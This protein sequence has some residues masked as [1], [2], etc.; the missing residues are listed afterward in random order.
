MK[1]VLFVSVIAVLRLSCDQQS[2]ERIQK[3]NSTV[4]RHV[5]DMHDYKE[6]LLAFV[7]HSKIALVYSIQN[8]ST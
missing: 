8:F 5:Q 7:A 4:V 6:T 1:E 3:K 2:E